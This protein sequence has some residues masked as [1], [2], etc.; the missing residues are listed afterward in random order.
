MRRRRGS[1]S[2]D[3]SSPRLWSFGFAL[4]G[5]AV[6]AGGGLGA[7]AHA[8]E[9]ADGRLE[10]HGY[11]ELQVRA[12]A[13][14]F[15]ASD[16]W[17][18]T[19]LAHVLNLELELDLLPEGVRLVDAA[20]LFARIEV[21]YDCV[22]SHALR[23][24]PERERLRQ[25]R[26]EAAEAAERRAPRR[27]RR[28]RLHRRHAPLP[29]RAPRH[30]RPA[31]PHSAR[32]RLARALRH[33]PHRRLLHRVHVAGP[34]PG[35]RHGGR[36]R[37]PSSSTATS[38]AGSCKFSSRYTRGFTDGNGHPEPRPASTRTATSSRSRPSP[39]SR[40]RSAP[41]TST[42]STACTEGLALPYRPAPEHDFDASAGDDV[43]RGP[44]DSE[45]AAR[46]RLIRDDD[47]DD[48]EL[49]LLPGRR[50][51]GTTAPARTSAS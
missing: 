45:R 4:L 32:R 8:A 2:P 15:R 11:Y 49:Q 25:Q 40:T 3:N 23:A 39:T 12:I 38:A 1:H 47:F 22:W 20:S 51:P 13:R 33:R 48:P 28:E 36:S 46:A 5:L 24:V 21:R 30:L 17:D 19:Q 18:V 37:R 35:A 31:R 9:W 14:D 29:R 34:G 7:P 42:R 10:L 16:D 27:L 26:Q 43:A 50:W 44:L 6:W 41:A